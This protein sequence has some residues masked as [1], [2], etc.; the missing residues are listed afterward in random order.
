MSAQAPPNPH[1]ELATRIGT[2]ITQHL[3]RVL[4]EIASALGPQLLDSCTFSVDVVF[5]TTT[6]GIMVDIKTNKDIPTVPADPIPLGFIGEALTLLPPDP[7]PPVDA[8]PEP[9]AAGY[10]A[11]QQ[12]VP[13]PPP[14]MMG[15]QANLATRPPPRQRRPLADEGGV[16]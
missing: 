3:W 4:P 14:P 5:R 12:A 13:Q 16:S 2:V 10:N 7:A 6:A 15:Q 9:Q 8:Q 1:D 11:A